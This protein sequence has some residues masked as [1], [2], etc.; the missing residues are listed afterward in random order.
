MKVAVQRNP[1]LKGEVVLTFANLP[2]GV[3]ADAAKIA[4][5]K[6]EVEV[7]LKAAADAAKGAAKNLT[8][9]GE[10]TVGKAKLAG[11]SAAIGLTVE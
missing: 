5:D 7:T 6:N 2:K 11:T 3:T 10:V 8:V 9:K 1:A 4:A